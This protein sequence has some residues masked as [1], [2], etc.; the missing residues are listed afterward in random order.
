M[1]TST[2]YG[3][4]GSGTPLVPSWLGSGSDG[5]PPPTPGNG[6]A[7]DNGPPPAPSPR[8]PLPPAGDPARFT[9][10]RTSFT[11]FAGSG[12]SDRTN[13]GRAVS[14][15]V[16]TASGGARQ[17]ARRMGTS[18]SA[19]ARLLSFLS[20]AQARGV[21]EALK[22]LNLE[23]LAG[24]SIEQVFV[25]LAEHICPDV[26]TVDEG[27]ACHAF[28]ETIIDL[29]TL[30]ITDLDGMTIDQMQTVFELYATHAIEA[31]LCNDI[32]TRAVTVP[33]DARVALRVQQQLHDF[34]R[35]GVSDALTEARATT[36]NLPQD[37]IQSFVDDVYERAFA[38]L[39]VLG[40]AE[41]EANR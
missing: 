35:R 2:A 13:L 6:P 27:I 41:V 1:G 40:E 31:R 38:I 7:D 19:G 10:A 32:G 12:G 22:T 20:D 3:G 8:P 25:G 28:V 16:S 15:Y 11:R 9:G 24:L 29:A 26:G 23:H 33:A 37:R 18:R 36:P 39:Q 5:V 17:A 4:P 34:I 14:R 21:R 30:G